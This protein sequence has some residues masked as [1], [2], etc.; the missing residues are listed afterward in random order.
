M[1]E[2]LSFYRCMLCHHVVSF[3]DVKKGGCQKCKNRRIRPTDLSIF[4]KIVQIFK[5]PRIWAW[6]ADSDM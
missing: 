6:P 1:R 5:H 2:G 3:W 4:E